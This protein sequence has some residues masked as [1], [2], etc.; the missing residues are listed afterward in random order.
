ML[1]VY[2]TKRYIKAK[3]LHSYYLYSMSVLKERFH[4]GV[5]EGFDP[6]VPCGKILPQKGLTEALMWMRKHFSMKAA[7]APGVGQY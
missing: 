3:L 4:L 6:W 5:F 7:E 2:R 1:Q